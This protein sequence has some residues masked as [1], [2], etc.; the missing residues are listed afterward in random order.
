M[1]RKFGDVMW[2]NRRLCIVTANDLMSQKCW[3][4][5]PGQR[6][7][8]IKERTPKFTSDL[9][10]RGRTAIRVMVGHNLVSGQGVYWTL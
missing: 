8:F 10:Q 7:A 4:E 1:N 5:A 6:Q 2:N 3:C 9:L